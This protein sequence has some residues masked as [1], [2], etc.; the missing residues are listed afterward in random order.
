MIFLQDLNRFI[1]STVE[2]RFLSSLPESIALYSQ[3]LT[4]LK[5][6][7]HHCVPGPCYIYNSTTEVSSSI[8][9][10]S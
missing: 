7:S 10:Y 2:L 5:I 6:Y 3:N 1:L 9:L 8:K 4:L